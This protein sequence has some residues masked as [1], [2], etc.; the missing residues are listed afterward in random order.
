MGGDTMLKKAS[1]GYSKVPNLVFKYKTAKVKGI[2]K[3]KCQ[4]LC[5][6]RKHCKSF[7][8]NDK[9]DICLWSMDGLHYSVS[10]VWYTKLHGSNYL[11]KGSYAAFPGLKYT[12]ASGNGIEKENDV[13]KCQADC[14]KSKGCTS[15]SYAKST[16]SCVLHS[17]DAV[18]ERGWNYYQKPVSD[19]DTEE[20]HRLTKRALPELKKK[21]DE[22]LKKKMDKIR[23]EKKQKADAKLAKER[24]KKI[25]DAS[26]EVARKKSAKAKELMKKQNE[27]ALKDRKEILVKRQATEKKTKEMATK[28]QALA[29]KKK[30][31]LHACIASKRKAGMDAERQS[32]VLMRSTAA[33]RKGKM[34]E[35]RL[36]ALVGQ[37][38]KGKK[39]KN[40]LRPKVQNAA[41]KKLNKLRGVEDKDMNKYKV[42]SKTSD[43]LE[44]LCMKL[45]GEKTQAVE[46][47]NKQDVFLAH[48]NK[49]LQHA[50]KIVID[51]TKSGPCPP[52]KGTRALVP[53][54]VAGQVKKNQ[55]A[56][57]H[58]QKR[59]ERFKKKSV[60]VAKE[61][62]KKAEKKKKLGIER[63][64]KEFARKKKEKGKKEK[65]AKKKKAREM[66][67]KEWIH[68]AGKEAS[69][70]R[71]KMA[72]ASKLGKEKYWKLRVGLCERHEKSV[73]LRLTKQE[74]RH[75]KSGDKG[76]EA[77]NEIKLYQEKTHK[78][79]K[80][81]EREKAGQARETAGKKEV[82]AKEK[83]HKAAEKADE[84]GRKKEYKLLLKNRKL[85]EKK[86]KEKLAKAKKKEKC[87]KDDAK[88]K[89]Y[90]IVEK[91][92]EQHNKAKI[93]WIRVNTMEKKRRRAWKKAQAIEA[94]RKG[95]IKREHDRK[96]KHAKELGAKV[97]EKKSKEKKRKETKQKAAEKL[98]KHKEK[99]AKAQEKAHKAKEK[100][101]KAA[102][103]VAK[104]AAALE[105]MVKKGAAESALKEMKTKEKAGKA[106][107]KAA[108][109][110]EN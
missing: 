32:K 18:V 55:A 99:G 62:A 42:L 41:I 86:R 78:V 12:I 65:V 92:N 21:S 70:K 80:K 61:K 57:E 23:A 110:K 75:K 69:H 14:D 37:T 104:H 6:T 103:K 84:K 94:S 45:H 58:L 8:Y 93:E 52:C 46:K 56:Y 38:P 43:K 60:K 10:W 76:A 9:D 3:S 109:F 71:K 63:R 20:M 13:E 73:T 108:K 72:A 4:H 100:K 47:Q 101:A 11:T 2:S 34:Y 50:G 89:H 96:E 1:K 64:S 26:S 51:T 79:E 7:S 17:V 54:H 66:R 74:A 81:C 68:E 39:K 67:K 88:K 77:M 36:K 22:K 48:A 98:A 90:E 87:G 59:L 19:T 28:A 40:G 82:I 27:K 30:S 53:R 97:K 33:K 24:K 44:Q 95:I 25:T 5:D 107:E 31:D 106:A 15:F 29:T 85:S 49:L 83:D 105:R 35:L 102:E 16:K 91:Q